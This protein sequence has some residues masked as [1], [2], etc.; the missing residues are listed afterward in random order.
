M[1]TVGCGLR[2]SY[3]RLARHIRECHPEVVE[4]IDN[5][6]SGM[7]T[8]MMDDGVVLEEFVVIEGR[9]EMKAEAE[10]EERRKRKSPAKEEEG[11]EK[12]KRPEE[13]AAQKRKRPEEKRA[14]KR[15]RSIIKVTGK[16]VG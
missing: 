16:E 1:C 2:V 12:R 10:E 14:Q 15:K 6:D 11:I 3:N 5:A 4:D 13:E 9:K 7:A 8:S